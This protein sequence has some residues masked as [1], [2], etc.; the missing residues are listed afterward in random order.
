MQ[1][2]KN[3]GD[4]ELAFVD[5]EGNKQKIKPKEEI[6]CKYKRSMDSRLVILEK[7]SKKK[8]TEVKENGSK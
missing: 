6:T 3:I 2:V 7:E 1:I 5:D 8:K 4:G